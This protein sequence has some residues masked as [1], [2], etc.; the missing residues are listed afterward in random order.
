MRVLV[1]VPEGSLVKHRRSVLAAASLATALTVTLSACADSTSSRSDEVAESPLEAYLGSVMGS[2][3]SPEEQ[4]AENDELNRRV[5][6]AV[7]ECMTDQGFDYVPHTTSMSAD[8]DYEWLPDDRDWVAQYGYGVVDSPYATSDEGLVEEDPNTEYVESLSESEQ[9]A[10]Y[11][12]LHGPMP[13]EDEVVD[14]QAEY[15]WTS[16]GCYGEAQHDSQSDQTALFEEHD[17]LFEKMGA[18]YEDIESA[19][20]LVEANEAW[21]QCMTDA[22]QPGFARQTDA[23]GSIEEA[24][25]DLWAE[26]D[27]GAAE[28]DP[29]QSALDE[30][31]DTEIELALIDLDCR[32]ET[33]FAGISAAAS[34]EIEQRFIDEHKSELDA[35][36][37]DAE[38]GR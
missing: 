17:E 33:D 18:L 3:L 11:E 26:I 15:D 32:E 1:V 21:S 5:E 25:S 38:Q 34:A 9:E 36:K 16:A 10:Y 24:S 29:D 22:G 12:A 4:E 35:L 2:E 8:P 20:E 7:A 37:A 28:G 13:D 31:A 19:P 27:D 14:E 30:L 23:R 6:E